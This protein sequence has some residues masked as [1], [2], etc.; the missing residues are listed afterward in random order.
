M[1]IKLKPGSPEYQELHK[2][3]IELLRSLNEKEVVTNLKDQLY[4]FLCSAAEVE[5]MLGMQYLYTAFSLKKYPEEFSDFDP[6][7]VLDRGVNLTRIQQ[8]EQ[9]R[10]WEASILYVSRQEMEHLNLVQNLIAI[11][12]YDPYMYRPNFPVTAE[13]NPLKEPINLMRFSKHA[14]E[15][16]RYWEKPDQLPLPNPFL[17]DLPLGI[18]RLSSIRHHAGRA[19][20]E[21]QVILKAWRHL[22]NV[23][24]GKTD[25]IQVDS[26]E[27][28]YTI[29]KVYFYFLL[30][31]DFIEGQNLNRIVEEHF[32]FNLTLDPIVDGKFYEYVEQVIDQI[33]QEGEGVWGVPPPLDSHFM[34]FQQILDEL[35][36]M[37]LKSQVPVE[38]SLPCVFNPTISHVPEYH[39]VPVEKGL[40]ADN[41]N[42]ALYHVTNPT[43][44][45][46]M[47]LYNQA[48][49]VL[50]QMLYGFFKFYS[51][52][53][54]TGIRPP[55]PNAFFRTSFYPFMTM[56]MRPLGEI[57]CRLPADADFVPD[58]GK[59]PPRTAGP[60]FFLNMIQ[61]A[62]F[63]TINESFS[64]A[65][66]MS[67]FMVQFEEMSLK[68]KAIAEM[69]RKNGY[70]MANYQE[71]D[72]RDF[73][74][75][76]EYLSENFHRISENFENYWKGK[77]DA[78]IPS[79]NFQNF[80][81]TY[82]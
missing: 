19:F 64:D 50:I 20:D 12:G 61:G 60:N 45:A 80:S 79:K 49:N 46:A 42:S 47:E 31:H 28:L 72:S 3:A 17:A 62:S 78:P 69:C 43:T 5:H 73:D 27:E 59:V 7:Q 76:L 34:V 10:R 67:Y 21:A 32:G 51:I 41:E 18:K 14:L 11:L 30:E 65:M 77:I 82:N 6:S 74:T 2:S 13:Q 75:R 9:I 8:I 68:S 71:P 70:H 24:E 15:V 26:I 57:L 16:F 37:E 33:I 44:Q 52:D 56:V 55:V 23:V 66:E 39:N 53:Y 36:D 35:A 38:P 4:G 58:G 22:I 25:Q 48:Y 40:I 63:K 81:N 29:I 1:E 54:T